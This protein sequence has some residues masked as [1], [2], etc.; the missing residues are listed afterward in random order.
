M[1]GILP[2]RPLHVF[3]TWSVLSGH[4]STYHF[5]YHPTNLRKNVCIITTRGDHSE[6]QNII[7]EKGNMYLKQTMCLYL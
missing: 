7:F 6:R 2:P 1:R 4:F 5:I 3:M